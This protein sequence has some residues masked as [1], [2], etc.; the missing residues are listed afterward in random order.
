MIIKLLASEHSLSLSSSTF[1]L[2]LSSSTVTETTGLG[3][4]LQVLLTLSLSLGLD[5]V[6]DELTLVLE[7]V[8]LGEFVERVVEVLVEFS[9][10]SVLGQETTEDT[11]TSHPKNLGG[12]SGLGST[13]SLTI[14]SVST[15][16]LGGVKSSGTGSSLT[17]GWLGDDETVGNHLSDGLTRVSVADFRDFVRVHPDLS[18][19]DA[20][21]VGGESLLK[22]EV[23]PTQSC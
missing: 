7:G 3:L 4:L 20:H 12:H 11:E 5:D 17:K 1:S 8:T 15:G 10:V 13:L 2:S 19:A 14:T 18:L 9:R 16:T 23:G 22:R 21:H 6:L